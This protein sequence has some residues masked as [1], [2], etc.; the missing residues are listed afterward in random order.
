MQNRRY[1]RTGGF[2]F[3]GKLGTKADFAQRAG[4]AWREKTPS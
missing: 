4:V 2:V 3:K 1:V